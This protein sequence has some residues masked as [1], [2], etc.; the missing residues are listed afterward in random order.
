MR[1][2]WVLVVDILQVVS[3]RTIIM[4]D[5]IQFDSRHRYVSSIEGIQFIFFQPTYRNGMWND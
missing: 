2:I 3:E 4:V 5:E 1:Q